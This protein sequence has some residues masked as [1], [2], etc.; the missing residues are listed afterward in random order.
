MLVW[1]KRKSESSSIRGL[2]TAHQDELFKA[3]NRA[4]EEQLDFT[5]TELEVLELVFHY[6][7]FYLER[8]RG[9]QTKQH[10][11]TQLTRLVDLGEGIRY[12]EVRLSILINVIGAEEVSK[13][14]RRLEE[15]RTS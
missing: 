4:K 14:V 9:R 6:V 7:F 10:Y 5:S 11:L 3:I 2:R 13:L 15:V 8:R 1:I 12:G